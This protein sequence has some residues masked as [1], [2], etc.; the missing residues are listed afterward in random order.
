MEDPT[1]AMR[2]LEEVRAMGVRF[3]VD[4]FG[5]GYSSLAYLRQLPID[6]V[7]IDRSFVADLAHDDT[8]VRAVIDLA[9]NLGLDV[10]AEGVEEGD[11]EARL[12]DLGCD[13]AQGFHWST[14]MPV[15]DLRRWL[16]AFWTGA[17]AG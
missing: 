9:H 12:R 13:S 14:P 16:S 5:T 2:T 3:S 15:G 6:E 10:V 17:P 4:D 11:T 7:K 1:R 8:I